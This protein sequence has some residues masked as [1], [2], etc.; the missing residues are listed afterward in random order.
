MNHWLTIFSQLDTLNRDFAPHGI[1]FK[2]M[3]KPDHIKSIDWASGGP[4][5]LGD[6]KVVKN[7]PEYKVRASNLHYPDSPTRGLQAS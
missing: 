4:W 5:S 1:S 2:L 6:E 7:H 3:G